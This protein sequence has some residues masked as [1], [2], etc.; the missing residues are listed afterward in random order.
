MHLRHKVL[1]LLFL[2]II[3]AFTLTKT[4][5]AAQ[6]LGGH[7]YYSF[8]VGVPQTAHHYVVRVYE[9]GTDNQIAQEYLLASGLSPDL[10]GY[11][12]VIPTVLTD[13]YI[14]HWG[15]IEVDVVVTAYDIDWVA[16]DDST[17]VILDHH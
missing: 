13:Q 11:V 12:Y 5:Q 8:N 16:K 14:G 17:V 1:F 15:N 7:P 2:T 10:A 9:H 4:V 6:Q 3:A